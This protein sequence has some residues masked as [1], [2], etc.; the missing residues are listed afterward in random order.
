MGNIYYQLAKYGAAIKMWRMAL[1][2]LPA[3]ARELRGRVLRNI[4]LAFVKLGQYQDALQAFDTVVD[5]GLD[6]QAA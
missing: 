6:H 4:G 2:Q 1:D 3:S 5:G